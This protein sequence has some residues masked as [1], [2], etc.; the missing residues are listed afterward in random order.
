MYLNASVRPFA[1]ITPVPWLYST[2]TASP[3]ESDRITLAP[4]GT[5]ANQV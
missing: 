3:L 5:L 4:A 2:A 1:T